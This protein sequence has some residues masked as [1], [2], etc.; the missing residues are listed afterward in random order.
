MNKYKKLI[1]AG[2]TLVVFTALIYTNY[3]HL[4]ECTWVECDPNSAECSENKA[5]LY[6]SEIEHLKIEGSDLVCE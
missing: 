2:V 3:Y 4:T 6:E 5:Y 1:V